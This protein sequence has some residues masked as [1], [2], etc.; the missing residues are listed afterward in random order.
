MWTEVGQ[1][2]EVTPSWVCSSKYILRSESF[3]VRRMFG[4]KPLINGL[5]VSVQFITLADSDLL[6]ELV[7]PL[8]DRSPIH[9]FLRKRDGFYH[10]CFEVQDLQSQLDLEKE[11]HSKIVVKPTKAEAFQNDAGRVASNGLKDWD[12]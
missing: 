12:S 5:D 4:C 11:K 6:V 10:V 7:E 2:H 1:Y 3:T 9:T 8:S